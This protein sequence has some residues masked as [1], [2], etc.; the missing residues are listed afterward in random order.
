MHLFWKL[1][2]HTILFQFFLL[3]EF[4]HHFFILIGI[5]FNIFISFKFFSVFFQPDGY[6]HL[7]EIKQEFRAA[8]LHRQALSCA[9]YALRVEFGSKLQRL[10]S[11]ACGDK[12]S[13][14]QARVDTVQNVMTRNIEKLTE[15]GES[16]ADLEGRSEELAVT[17]TD[18]HRTTTKLRKKMMWK[19]IKLWVIFIIVLI[20]ILAIIVGVI[21]V[22]LSIKKKI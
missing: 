2:L 5:F 12:V 11:R 7:E 16:L 6:H 10:N 18:F 19:S 21:V 9:P 8:G 4:Q 20:I 13:D 15:R 3:R 22:V 17:S 14:L 1:I